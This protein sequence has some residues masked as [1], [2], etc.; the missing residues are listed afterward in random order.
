MEQFR[1]G[2]VISEYDYFGRQ[3]VI[4]S[5]CGQY[6][7]VWKMVTEIKTGDT[8]CRNHLPFNALHLSMEVRNE[9]VQSV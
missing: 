9:S 8:F 2:C 7:F 1:F 6:D 4:C 3:R 5:V